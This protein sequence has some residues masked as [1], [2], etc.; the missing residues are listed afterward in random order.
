[1]G[2]VCRFPGERELVQTEPEEKLVIC[3]VCVFTAGKRLLAGK[4]FCPKQVARLRA[5][6]LSLRVTEFA[7]EGLKPSV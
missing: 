6:V 5:G 1:M 2:F 7:G 3:T 4:R